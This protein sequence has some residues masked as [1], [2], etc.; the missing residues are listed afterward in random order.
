MVQTTLEKV[1]TLSR[2]LHPVALDEAGF[3]SALDDF[4]PGFEKQTGIRVAY[5][6]DGE[7]REIDRGLGIHLYRVMQEALNNVARHSK[8]PSAAVRLRYREDSLV[9]EIEDHGIGFGARDN[10]QGMGMVSMRERAEMLNGSVGILEPRRR[11]RA[12][13]ANR[14]AGGR[15]GAGLTGS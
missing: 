7:G 3:E 12:G 10:K 4:L 13:A 1:R 9:L 2:A 15:R 6:K 5:S 11:R 14:A 8:S